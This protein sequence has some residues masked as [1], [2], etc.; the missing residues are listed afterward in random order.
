MF[1]KRGS[2]IPQ[3]PVMQYIGEKKMRRFGSEVFPALEGRSASFVLYED[4]GETNDYKKDICSKTEVK[5]ISAKEA[6]KVNILRHNENGRNQIID[7]ILGSKYIWT[8]PLNR[9]Y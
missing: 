8:R 4:D 2:I 1:V 7:R 6:W 5:C 3:I 9:S